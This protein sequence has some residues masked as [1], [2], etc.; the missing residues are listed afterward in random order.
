[1]AMTHLDLL[2]GVNVFNHCCFQ[3][4]NFGCVQ[5]CNICKQ[6]NRKRRIR[7][8]TSSSKKNGDGWLMMVMM[9]MRREC[10]CVCVYF[11]LWVGVWV[12]NYLPKEV[13]SSLRMESFMALPSSTAMRV[14]MSLSVAFL[15]TSDNT[16]SSISVDT[17]GSNWLLL[18][19]VPISPLLVPIIPF[20]SLS[21]NLSS[22][23]KHNSATFLKDSHLLSI[24]MCG[25]RREAPEKL[26]FHELLLDEG[27]PNWDKQA[28]LLS[29]TASCCS[30][31]CCSS[32]KEENRN[33][34]QSF[35]ERERESCGAEIEKGRRK[36]H[37]H[38][39]LHYSDDKRRAW[40]QVIADRTPSNC[41]TRT[42]NSRESGKERG[43]QRHN[44]NN[45]KDLQA[46]FLRQE[47]PKSILQFLIFPEA[48]K[49]KT[50]S[51][52]YHF[53][54]GKKCQIPFSN[55]SFF[56]SQ[57]I[58]QSHSPISHTSLAKDVST[59]AGKTR[60]DQHWIL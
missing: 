37:A 10:V 59:C 2:H 1:M 36:R 3:I 32:L 43:A 25:T 28:N 14:S 47:I 23:A 21:L 60:P 15:G 39:Y 55:F 57:E 50:H 45:N 41:E 40:N 51:P 29:H 42:R 31:W 6:A 20:F 34:S 19:Y 24:T 8:W 49:A 33:F 52:I 9:V 12:G 46:F 27:N 17:S 48:R 4:S 22:S 35:R 18:K 58:P 11:L 13:P 56:L 38:A 5:N 44:N 30:R 26:R 53:S 54:C 7:C 16:G